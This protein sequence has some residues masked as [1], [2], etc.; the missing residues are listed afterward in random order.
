MTK[1]D[2]C[3]KEAGNPF[4][5]HC[6]AASLFFKSPIT[7]IF[8]LLMC[9][10]FGHCIIAFAVDTGYSQNAP[11]MPEFGQ[12][13]QITVVPAGYGFGDSVGFFITNATGNE[14][15]YDV[16]DIPLKEGSPHPALEEGSIYYCDGYRYYI[17]DTWIPQYGF[18]IPFFH[19]MIG[20]KNCRDVN[21][22]PI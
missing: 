18:S 9:I 10:V 13:P 1:C 2:K 3:G 6:R 12:T 20:I 21:G 15:F 19:H 11:P 5:G 14:Y 7:I 22:D 17:S 16:K 4:C 8:I